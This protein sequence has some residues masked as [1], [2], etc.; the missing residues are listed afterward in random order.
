MASLVDSLM[1]ELDS[2]GAVDQIAGKLGLPPAQASSA[3]SA[4]VP[5][6]LAGLASNAQKPEG[7]AALS[8][9]LERD[10]DGSV[11]NDDSYFDSYEERKGDKILGHVFGEKEPAV[12]SQVSSLAGLSG[13]QGAD[14]MK[15]LAPL[16]MGYLGK[17]KSSGSLDL[18][19]LTQ[20]LA[21]GGGGLNL[22]GGLG[23]LIGGLSGGG[24][25]P[26]SSGGAQKQSSGLGGIL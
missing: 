4:A 25:A 9:A 20:V 6:I 24:S 11:L 7:A 13:A 17:Q 19:S 26:A 3:V 10:H 21:G 14:L 15:M 16:I 23:D 18:S 2:R 5:A 22:P 12:E 8:G 1:N